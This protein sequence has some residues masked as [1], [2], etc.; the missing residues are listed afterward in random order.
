MSSILTYSA[1]RVKDGSLVALSS[2][3]GTLRARMEGGYLELET[4]G[5]NFAAALENAYALDIGLA[6]AGVERTH[7][8]RWDPD[9]ENASL[10]SY[11]GKDGK[12]GGGGLF[13]LFR[14]DG[15]NG[16]DGEDGADAHEVVLN[17]AY[18]TADDGDRILIVHDVYNETTRCFRK[19]PVTVNAR[20]GAGGDGQDGEDGED[21]EEGDGRDEGD[22][23][24]GGDGGSGG[25][26]VIHYPAGMDIE[27][28]VK[29]HNPGGVGGSGGTGWGSGTNGWS[30]GRGR[31]GS[32]LLVPVTD[33][34][35]REFFPIEEPRFNP[36]RV[37]GG[38]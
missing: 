23:G 14:G 29:V 28:A 37:T 27:A 33:I 15:D 6:S 20:G 35:K 11:S 38:A 4:P 3:N 16:L 22:G 26:V 18:Y 24:D 25:K 36:G 34:K 17:V 21:D 9:W 31:D 1:Y 19:W 7:S 32:T 12:D 13:S 2:P 10:P 5:E 30:G 8:L